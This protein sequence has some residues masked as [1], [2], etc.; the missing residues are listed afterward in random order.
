M[1]VGVPLVMARMVSKEE[2]GEPDIS[3]GLVKDL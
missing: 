1:H 3:V 2:Q